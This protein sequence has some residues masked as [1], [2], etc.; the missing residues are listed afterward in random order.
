MSAPGLKTYAYRNALR[1]SLEATGWRGCAW[2]A[3]V[4]AVECVQG[5]AG[6]KNPKGATMLR[7]YCTQYLTPH[8]TKA[9]AKFLQDAGVPAFN[10][11]PIREYSRELSANRLSQGDT[12]DRFWLLR[13]YNALDIGHWDHWSLTRSYWGIHFQPSAEEAMRIIEDPIFFDSMLTQDWARQEHFGEA[14]PW[15]ALVAKYHEQWPNY[16]AM[17]QLLST[18]TMSTEEDFRSTH[19]SL[20]ASYLNPK[21]MES[22]EL[23]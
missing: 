1:Q 19:R 6:R 10:L 17:V 22:F 16:S 4:L 18:M 5:W 7:V 8:N 23:P 15:E 3:N 20:R 2:A 11:V 9:M 12:Q 13:G 14:S 21:P